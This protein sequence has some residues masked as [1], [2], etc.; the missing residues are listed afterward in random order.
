ML[1]HLAS[2]GLI[3]ALHEPPHVGGPSQEVGRAPVAADRVLSNLLFTDIADSTVMAA[4]M[5]DRHLEFEV[6]RIGGILFVM[7]VLQAANVV[8]LTLTGRLL[9]SGV[10]ASRPPGEQT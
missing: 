7:G 5:G 9:S 2:A 10:D 3:Q 8:A 4:D 1:L 6:G